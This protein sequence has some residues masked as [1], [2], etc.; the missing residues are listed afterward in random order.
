MEV[1]DSSVATLVVVPL[2]REIEVIRF[3]RFERRVAGIREAAEGTALPEQ[4]SAL[5]VIVIR[6]AD[7]LAIRCAEQ[8]IVN[9]LDVEVD[10]RQ[11]VIVAAGQ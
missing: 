9:D 5:D 4:E 1:T 2:E 10:V 11:Q 7:R 3:Q 8:D 6:S